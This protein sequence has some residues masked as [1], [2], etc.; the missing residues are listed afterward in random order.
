MSDETDSWLE[1][2]GVSF[3]SV[4]EAF[5]A[6]SDA[7][8]E[9][10]NAAPDF[11]SVDVGPIVESISDAPVDEPGFV[12]EQVSGIQAEEINQPAEAGQVEAIEGVEETEVTDQFDPFVQADVGGATDTQSRATIT[13]DDPIGTLPLISASQV[14]SDGKE[15]NVAVPNTNKTDLLF[16]AA[17]SGRSVGTVKISFPSVTLS[18]VQ[19]IAI[20]VGRSGIVEMKLVSNSAT[21][22]SPKVKKS[23]K[24]RPT[25]STLIMGEP[26][27]V[28]ALFSF[29]QGSSRKEFHVAV[30]SSQKDALLL[31]ASAEGRSF[32][33]V[34][35]STPRPTVTMKNVII[36]GIDI[37]GRSSNVLMTLVSDS[38]P[39]IDSE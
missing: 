30:A 15:F 6:E 7:V 21:P 36:S 34:V 28:L 20:D 39:E 29:S 32:A 12:T 17:A 18:N 4:N 33:T 31:K 1:T 8:V 26:I 2:L 9:V 24:P 13:M 22:P 25:T 16:L 23:G 10:V 35:I 19:I 14:D 3:E 11:E 5:S 27:G 37:S 38:P